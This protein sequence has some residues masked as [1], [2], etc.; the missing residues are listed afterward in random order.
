MAENKSDITIEF[1]EDSVKA[2]V[3]ANIDSLV[4]YK[5]VRSREIPDDNHEALITMYDEPDDLA[6]DDFHDWGSGW[7]S[8]PVG[9][10]L[11]VL[12]DFSIYRGDAGHVPDRVSVS[13][14]DPELDHYFD[15]QDNI[16]VHV[17]FTLSAHVDVSDGRLK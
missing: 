1:L 11:G 17:S 12:I 6:V 4:G 8:I 13:F 16:I 5:K 9:F 2:F 7:I 10:D 3:A 15:A 14:G